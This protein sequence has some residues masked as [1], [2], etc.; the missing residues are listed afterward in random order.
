[1]SLLDY[2]LC[3]VM[4]APAGIDVC[5]SGV[6][7]GNKR[8]LRSAVRQISHAVQVNLG[9]S[10]FGVF[11][12]KPAP[13]GELNQLCASLVGTHGDIGASFHKRLERLRLL[14]EQAVFYHSAVVVSQ[15]LQG[16]A[17]GHQMQAAIDRG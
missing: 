11:L 15:R 2:S 10:I 12:S 7:V 13:L 14:Q 17:G 5:R 8:H 9:Q 1:M 4:L 3:S 16:I 6:I